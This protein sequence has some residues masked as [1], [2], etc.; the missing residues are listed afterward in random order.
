MISFKFHFETKW[1]LQLR[2]I[3]FY[4]CDSDSSDGE[5]S[6]SDESSGAEPSDDTDDASELESVAAEPPTAPTSES[7]T[8]FLKKHSES[9]QFY[10][11]TLLVS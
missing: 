6:N 7:R 10:T 5:A 2:I 9:Y 4:W 1:N 11:T 8:V 3:I